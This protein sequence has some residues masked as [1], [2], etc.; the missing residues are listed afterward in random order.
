MLKIY[1]S[2]NNFLPLH[3][4]MLDFKPASRKYLY[5]FYIYSLN[6]NRTLYQYLYSG[7]GSKKAVK[8]AKGL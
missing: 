7:K 4:T 5:L 2:M 6:K 1:E 8:R 3:K